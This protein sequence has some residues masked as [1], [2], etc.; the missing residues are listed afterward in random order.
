M[1][2]KLDVVVV[3][4]KAFHSGTSIASSA[5]TTRGNAVG[6]QPVMAAFT[7]TSSTVA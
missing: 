6:V 2:K 5:A 1:A 7:A 3:S 4:P